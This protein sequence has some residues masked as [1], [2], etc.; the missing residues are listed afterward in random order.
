MQIEHD[1]SFLFRPFNIAP[2]FTIR[3]QQSVPPCLGFL[4]SECVLLGFFCCFLGGWF[5]FLLF[6]FQT[7]EVWKY[8]ALLQGRQREARSTLK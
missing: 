5:F 7:P 3:F 1:S 4:Y 6:R 2:I 8:Q